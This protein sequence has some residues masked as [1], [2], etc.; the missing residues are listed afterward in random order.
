MGSNATAERGGAHRKARTLMLEPNDDPVTHSHSF[1]GLCLH[2]RAVRGTSLDDSPCPYEYV[3]SLSK[4]GPP[5]F[6]FLH[7]S[8]R[9][10]RNP[11]QRF[12][13]S[14][15]RQHDHQALHHRAGVSP[16]QDPS[17]LILTGSASGT[18]PTQRHEIGRSEIKILR[19]TQDL[20]TFDKTKRKRETH[21]S[22]AASTRRSFDDR[23]HGQLR[24]VIAS[25]SKDAF[26]PP[27]IT[28]AS[29]ETS[30]PS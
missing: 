20:T 24:N 14:E 10:S 17:P 13:P 6:D 4:L 11:M 15:K 12:R 25:P 3:P 21:G 9:A 22:V 29:I 7:A 19:G 5:S 1:L 28:C 27:V 8:N 16:S 2:V 23:C 26:V 30:P 18:R